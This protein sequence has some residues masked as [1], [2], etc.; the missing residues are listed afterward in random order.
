VL[1]AG[2]L[3]A[4]A[5]G[6]LELL[7]RRQLQ[8]RPVGRRIRL[9]TGDVTDTEVALRLGRQPEL[10]DRVAGALHALV[11][12]TVGSDI[13][14]PA[15]LG[16]VADAGGVEL[17]L[18]QPTPPP[19]PWLS[20]S[21]GF[22]WRLAQDEARSARPSF[23]EPLPA[24]AP[25][26]KAA[27]GQ[28][29]VLINL[30]AAGVLTVTGGQ[31]KSS[32]IIRAIA[33][34]L[35][36]LPW[37][38]ALN[39][40]L[41]GFGRELEVAPQIRSV[42]CL[43]HILP[44]L[45]STATVMADLLCH[46]GCRDTQEARLKGMAGDGWPPTVVLCATTPA[47]GELD[48][49]VDL[50]VAGQGVAAVVPG[51]AGT[52]GG[53]TLAADAA[54]MPINP[55]RLAVEPCP[56]PVAD[57]ISLGQLFDT[58]ADLTGVPVTEPPYDR[59][60]LSVERPEPTTAPIQ[61]APSVLIRVLGTVEVEGAGDFK[62]AKSRELAVY[63]AMHPHG[64]G[65]AELDEALWPSERG[66][67]VPASTRDSTVSVAR[68]ALG[69]PER[70]RP[71]QGQGREKRYQVSSE[72]GSDFATFCALHREARATGTVEPLCAALTLVRGRPFEGVLSGRTFTW[73]HTEGHARHVESEV[74]DAADLAATMFLEQGRPLDARWAARRGLTADPLC[75]RLWVRLM[76]AADDLGESHEI[77]RLMDDLNIVLELGGDYSG[78]H[79]NTLAAYERYRRQPQPPK[80][81]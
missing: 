40:V 60:E 61:T 32:G 15:I 35:S 2:L 19:A 26:G 55:L 37:S 22:R 24:L 17:L 30:E 36:G 43:A 5:F 23:S 68:T 42:A 13:T 79:P 44:E 3:S 6:V 74:G 29:D 10:V 7:R 25:I 45:R 50:A 62:R 47:Q 20:A 34:S 80:K 75:E 18:A 12:S 71:A 81:V 54:P 38:K 14:V 9:P 64:V 28:A 72:V 27:A 77:E 48:Q 57:L 33:T 76:Q 73:V 49:L 8:H 70:L 4:A 46:Q 51:V 21:E 11:E 59:I 39:L 52:A 67:V 53:W 65:E 31:T 58:A 66:R 69:G 16:V 78:L 1:E 56:L 63:L 41:V